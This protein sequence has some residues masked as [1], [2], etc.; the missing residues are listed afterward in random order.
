MNIML[1]DDDEAISTMLQ[2]IIEDYNLGEVVAVMNSAISLDNALLDHK[3]VDLLIMD[4]LMPDLDGIQA[5]HKIRQ[6]FGG[7]ILMLSQVESK[8]LVGKAYADGIDY[9]VTKPINRN[10]IVSV[11]KNVNE[12]LRLENFA[13]T[14]KSSLATL[15]QA[16]PPAKAKITYIERAESILGELGISS[17]PGAQDLLDICRYLERQKRVSAA[18][19]LKSI[20]TSVARSRGNSESF[21]KEAKA[22]EQRLRRTIYQG[23]INLATIGAVDYTNPKFEEYAPLFFDYADLRNTMHAIEAGE[24]RPCMSQIHINI[25][26]FIHA[27]YETAQR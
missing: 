17:S 21:D 4:M 6:G 15:N 2:D 1:I 8:D 12:R 25:K 14:L 5:A 9:Y 24:P 27:L 16:P 19:T 13:R 10:E 7:K 11:L 22:M 26:K 18:P 20:F 23:H 3:Q